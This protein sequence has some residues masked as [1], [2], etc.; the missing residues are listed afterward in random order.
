MVLNKSDLKIKIANEKLSKPKVTKEYLLF[1]MHRYRKCDP[2]R[3]ADRKMLVDT[4]V[5]VI[6]LYD[7]KLIITF[8]YKDSEKEISLTEIDESS[9]DS[10][11]TKIGSTP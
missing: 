7:D 11:D 8:N 1:W 9:S 6:Y 2:Q 10:S 4:F 3:L 5:N